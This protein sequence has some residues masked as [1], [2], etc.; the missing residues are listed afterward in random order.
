MNFHHMFHIC[1]IYMIGVEK[2]SLSINIASASTTLN[3]RYENSF[4]PVVIASD[5]GE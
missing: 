1:D 3:R 2:Q 4:L 5:Y